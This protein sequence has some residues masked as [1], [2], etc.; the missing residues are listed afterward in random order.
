MTDYI[1]LA[2]HAVEEYQA[3]LRAKVRLLADHPDRV[4]TGWALA[5][6]AVLDLFDGSSDE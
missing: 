1:E 5:V 3:D 2:E 4:M 6:S